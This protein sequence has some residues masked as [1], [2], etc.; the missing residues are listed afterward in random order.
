MVHV[1]PAYARRVRCRPCDDADMTSIAAAFR[2]EAEDLDT[3]VA[4]LDEAGWRRDTPA[5]GWTIAHQIGH[6]A[7]TDEMSL[8]ALTDPGAFADHAAAVKGNFDHV[9]ESAS[10]RAARDRARL[11]ADWRE[12]RRRVADAL[13]AVDPAS[14]VP[15]FGPPMRPR[16]MATARLME[17]WAHGQDVADALGVRRVP[18]D[19]L[20]DVCHLGVRTRDFAFRINGLEPPVGE[21]RIELT[22]P[23]GEAW[24]WGPEDAT[25]R[26]TGSAEDFCLVVAQRRDHQETSLVAEGP[27]AR[28]W[29]PIAQ[30]F[31]GPPRGQR[32]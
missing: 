30:V 28:Q 13:D 17:T 26:V 18:T 21:F 29:L 16:S 4:E 19:R 3:L 7:W 24:T 27:A 6:L 25:G 14:T 23:S 32:G 2:A 1:T 22:A 12:G 10:E 9:N 8:L 31:A 15:W 11:L 5:A 20:R